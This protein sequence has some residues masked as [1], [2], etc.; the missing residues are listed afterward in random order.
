MSTLYL[1]VE[2]QGCSFLAQN[3]RVFPAE[4]KGHCINTNLPA[5]AY[6]LTTQ[7]TVVSWCFERKIW[8][9]YSS[10]WIISSS[11][12]FW[13]KKWQTWLNIV[14]T[15]NLDSYY[16]WKRSDYRLPENR[17]YPFAPFSEHFNFQLPDGT[18]GS[19]DRG[20]YPIIPKPKPQRTTF[21]KSY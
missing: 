15:F 17:H 21:K 8:K 7:F 1:L 19:M 3:G 9:I 18:R 14:K 13:G 12:F 2:A 11:T 5:L 20:P 6:N 10:N 16:P 4:C